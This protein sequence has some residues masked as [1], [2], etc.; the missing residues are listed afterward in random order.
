MLDHVLLVDAIRDLSEVSFPAELAAVYEQDDL[1]GERWYEA[2]NV[3]AVLRV[4]ATKRRVHDDWSLLNGE[5]IERAD[6]RQRYDLLST[7]GSNSNF[8]TFAVESLQSIH[9]VDA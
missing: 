6:Q 1:L 9:L 8:A 3:G 2:Q 5:P 7:S 4:Q